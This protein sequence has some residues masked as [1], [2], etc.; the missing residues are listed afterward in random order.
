MICAKCRRRPN[1]ERQRILATEEV[2]GFLEQSDIS[3]KNITRLEQLAAIED[4]EFQELRNLVLKI[5]TVVP[6][7]RERWKK[8]RVRHPGLFQLAVRSNLVFDELDEAEM[9]FEHDDCLDPSFDEINL[10][11][12]EYSFDDERP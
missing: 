8:M 5:A 2:H 1:A 9:W 10:R 12:Q 11:L 7:K 3:Q 6:G 4:T